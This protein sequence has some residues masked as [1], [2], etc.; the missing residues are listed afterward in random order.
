MRA[1][2][3]LA[4]CQP[5]RDLAD[6]ER[7]GV[8]GEDRIARRPLLQLG[9]DLPFEREPPGAS[10]TMPAFAAAQAM[11]DPPITPVGSG[12]IGSQEIT[13]FGDPCRQPLQ[14]G[15]TPSWTRTS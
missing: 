9:E 1:E 6:R 15:R 14:R 11:D 5:G 2:D 12:A 4:R 8:A 7:R 10:M 13:C 3:A